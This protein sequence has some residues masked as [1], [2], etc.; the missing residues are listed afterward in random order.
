MK[1]SGVQMKEVLKKRKTICLKDAQ[2][3][4]N[5]FPMEVVPLTDISLF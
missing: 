2:R 5:L 4:K 3:H 1:E